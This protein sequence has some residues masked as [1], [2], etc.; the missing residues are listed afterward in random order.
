MVI[1]LGGIFVAV[2]VAPRVLN[3]AT[4]AGLVTAVLVIASGL[5]FVVQGIGTL[6]VRRRERSGQ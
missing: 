3:G 2:G 5:F 1:V 4:V 6:V